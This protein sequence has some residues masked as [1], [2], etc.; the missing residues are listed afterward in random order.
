MATKSAPLLPQ[1]RGPRTTALLHHQE[2]LP[3]NP[4][5]LLLFSPSIVIHTFSVQTPVYLQHCNSPLWHKAYGKGQA[6]APLPLTQ[7]WYVLLQVSCAVS[8]C[9]NTLAGEAIPQYLAN[10]MACP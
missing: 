5:V 10:L 4:H 1:L 9:S 7:V 8:F 6:L 2:P 3:A